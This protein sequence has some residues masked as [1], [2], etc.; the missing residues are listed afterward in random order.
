[1]T[2]KKMVSFRLDEDDRVLAKRLASR[3]QCR[4]SQIYRLGLLQLAQGLG[5]LLTDPAQLG[6]V[7]DLLIDHRA[8]FRDRLA[9]NTRQYFRMINLIP[10]RGTTKLKSQ[11]LELLLLPDH[12]I[13]QEI[14]RM[15]GNG[16]TQAPLER[17]LKQH[18][19]ERYQLQR[20][21]SGKVRQN[22]N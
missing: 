18:F 6:E 21:D 8:L 10:L 2:Q 11:D 16:S 9:M 1:M 13:G 20:P 22:L 14:Q 7:I 5:P 17:R 15:S 4:E 12:R 3:L 19:Y